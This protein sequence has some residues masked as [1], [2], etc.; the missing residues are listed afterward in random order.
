MKATNMRQGQGEKLKS[1]HE[2][3]KQ[4]HVCKKPSHPWG[5]IMHGKAH[6]CSKT[7]Y[8]KFVLERGGTP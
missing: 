4:C 3:L 6:V 8:C 7:C 1:E 2:P 5:R